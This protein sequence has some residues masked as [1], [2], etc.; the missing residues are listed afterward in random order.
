MYMNTRANCT[1]KKLRQLATLL[2]CGL[3]S[4]S[5]VAAQV[6]LAAQ[7]ETGL[8][9][10]EIEFVVEMQIQSFDQVW[11]TIKDTHWDPD[12]AG[13]AWD[14]A[15]DQLRP[16]ISEASSVAEVREVLRELLGTLKQS[17]CVIIPG[18]EARALEEQAQRGGPGVSGL[19]VRYVD[20]ALVVT[21]V[22]EGSPG[23]VAGIR[24][25]WSVLSV[26]NEPASDAGNAD[27]NPP[28]IAEELIVRVR[29]AVEHDVT[30]IET[31]LGMAATSVLTGSIGNRLTVE[32]SDHENATQTKKLELVKGPGAAVKLGTLPLTNVFFES[33]KLPGDIGYI[34]FN[35]FLDPGRLMKEFQQALEQDYAN[36]NGLVIDLRGNIGGL[37]IMTQ[38]MSGW[39]VDE[40][41]SL[42]RM[43][44][45]S[46][47]LQLNV[48][49]RR[50][51]FMPPVAVLIDECSISAA[52]IYAGGLLDI[53]AARVFGGRSAGLVLPSSFT[54][55]PN[56]DGFL[57]AMA[58]YKSSS[59]RVLEGQGVEPQE[60]I[61]LTREKL[62]QDPD[63]TLSAAIQWIKTQGDATQ[64]GVTD[65]SAGR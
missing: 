7:V 58:D 49:P 30:R 64:Q 43:T 20:G 63:P 54:K 2:F 21:N 37:L 33:R 51:K 34:A 39:F 3:C 10:S 29:Q 52:E 32:F 45:K 31:A 36:S 42:G 16:R 60:K 61:I 50:P 46:T 40:P 38:G 56:G 6:T 23:A 27:G 48:N 47:P 26:A 9:D 19:T 41:V 62:I 8:P 25:G 59:G 53:K 5:F 35:A 17:H 24:A 15:R 14:A 28:V 18:E 11:K 1:L 57:Y 55:L 65:S 44:M 12:V 13:D 4:H 22:A